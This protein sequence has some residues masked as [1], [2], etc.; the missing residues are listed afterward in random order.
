MAGGGRGGRGLDGQGFALLEEA[1]LRRGARGFGGKADDGADRAHHGAGRPE[2][3]R[4]GADPSGRRGRAACCT[5]PAAPPRDRWLEASP[6]EGGPAA[7]HSAAQAGTG[8][9]PPRSVG[10]S[11]REARATCHAD[12]VRLVLP[13]PF[14]RGFQLRPQHCVQGLPG[15]LPGGHD[16]GSLPTLGRKAAC[17]VDLGRAH[18]ATRM[19]AV[20]ATTGGFPVA[21]GGG[22]F[23]R[24]LGSPGRRPSAR[25]PGAPALWGSPA[26]SACSAQR[27]QSSACS[28]RP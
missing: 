8:G 15:T 3:Q 26:S 22:R 24:R 11:L 9:A 2:R 10:C 6:N 18:P 17:Q 25:P 14:V 1:A 20:L 19:A 5:R 16:A 12:R 21:R 13:Q 27:W 7:A 23:T 4:Q 28:S